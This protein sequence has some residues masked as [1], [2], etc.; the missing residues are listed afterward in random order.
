M[1]YYDSHNVRKQ[2]QL[3]NQ[4]H[5]TGIES[6]IDKFTYSNTGMQYRFSKGKNKTDHIEF[7]ST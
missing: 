7:E 2:L 4:S 3:N 1:G 5:M 6:A